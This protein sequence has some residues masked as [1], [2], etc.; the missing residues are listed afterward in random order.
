MKAPVCGIGKTLRKGFGQKALGF[1]GG[2]VSV[3]F[4]AATGPGPAPSHLP[5][6][7]R[8]HA[9]GREGRREGSRE[10]GREGGIA[11]GIKAA[12]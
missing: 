9:G 5:T 7:E 6:A 12:L 11:A 2:C 10:G 1:G 3:G 4:A 8:G